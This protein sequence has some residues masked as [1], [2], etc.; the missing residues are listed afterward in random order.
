M[1]TI[2]ETLNEALQI[3]RSENSKLLDIIEDI[4]KELFRNTG[5]A[6]PLGLPVKANIMSTIGGERYRR[7]KYEGYALRGQDIL[8]K[9]EKLEK[10]RK[11]N[12]RTK[13]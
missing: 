13:S 1:K 10:L 9:L 2:E 3:D 6:W 4:A 8:R 11:P 7:A 12:E 5:D